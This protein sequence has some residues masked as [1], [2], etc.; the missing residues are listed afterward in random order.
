MFQYCND[1]VLEENMVLLPETL[2]HNSKRYSE[3]K[4]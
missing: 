2:P 4:I 1:S 3:M